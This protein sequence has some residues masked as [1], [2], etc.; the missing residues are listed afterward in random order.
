MLAKIRHF[1]NLETLTG[2]YH[3][4]FAS[5]L[6]YSCQI[7]G[8][9]QT[10]TQAWLTSLQ[11]KALRI[12]YFQNYN[13]Q[14]NIL[15][16]LS[17]ILKLNDQI[18]L[19]NCLFVWDVLYGELPTIFNKYFTRSHEVHGRNLRSKD[20]NNLFV[21]QSH[22]VNYGLYSITHQCVRS[23][24]NLPNILKSQPILTRSRTKFLSTLKQHYLDNYK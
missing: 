9:K 16:Y 13:F 3:A 7:W 24:N 17:K 11:N 1:T 19:S 21:K 18:E 14:P 20:N 2:I 10:Q 12:I 15:Y 8:Q 23:W 22:T 4:I 6:R 5:H